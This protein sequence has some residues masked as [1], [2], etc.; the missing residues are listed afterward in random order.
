VPK[1]PDEVILQA[2]ADNP[3]LSHRKLAT[4]AGTH[5]GRVKQVLDALPPPPPPPIIRL[6]WRAYTT[7]TYSALAERLAYAVATRSLASR[8]IRA[9]MAEKGAPQDS[10]FTHADD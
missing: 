4:L 2:H 8:P 5:P 7:P 9:L 3:T 1:V 6:N 10:E